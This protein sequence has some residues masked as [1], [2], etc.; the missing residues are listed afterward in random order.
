MVKLEDPVAP[1]REVLVEYR[2]TRPAPDTDIFRFG[3][4]APT[5]PLRPSKGPIAVLGASDWALDSSRAEKTFAHIGALGGLLADLGYDIYSLGSLAALD[6]RP[7]FIG[8]VGGEES[9]SEQAQLEALDVPGVSIGPGVEGV[10]AMG[11]V[12]PDD[13]SDSIELVRAAL[14]EIRR[15]TDGT[16]LP[17]G[18]P[19]GAEISTVPSTVPPG[20]GEHGTGPADYGD[21]RNPSKRARSGTDGDGLN[22]RSERS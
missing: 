3:G 18:T 10:A 5:L 7:S 2:R 11:N 6:Q 8:W 16:D 21:P 17:K 22:G 1:F 19:E 12:E 15:V 4:Q 14:H 9:T 13:H 20:T